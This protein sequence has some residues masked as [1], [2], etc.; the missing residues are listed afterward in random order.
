MGK[1]YGEDLKLDSK[2]LINVVM[3]NMRIRKDQFKKL[4]FNPFL[5]FAMIL[6]N[7]GIVYLNNLLVVVDDAK[8]NWSK[9]IDK[10]KEGVIIA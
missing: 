2:K 1:I 5:D 4:G 7:I 8:T 3:E 10:I 6:D 9:V